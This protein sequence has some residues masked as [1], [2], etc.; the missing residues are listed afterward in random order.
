MLCQEVT[1]LTKKTFTTGFLPTD[2]TG[3][4]TSPLLGKTEL[5]ETLRSRQKIMKTGQLRWTTSRLVMHLIKRRLGAI[6]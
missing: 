4:S 1:V 2:L 3:A 5:M 6:T